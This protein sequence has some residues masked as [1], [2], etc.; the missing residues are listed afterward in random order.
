MLQPLRFF[1]RRKS[2]R[3]AG[4]AA[5]FSWLAL[6]MS[7]GVAAVSPGPTPVS[8]AANTYTIE[9][10]PGA[11]LHTALLRS[12]ILDPEHGAVEAWYRQR[13]DPVPYKHNPHRIF[14]GP[15]GLTGVDEVNL[16]SQDRLDS[17]DP[18]L[19]FTV[20]FG[21]E[22]PPE[23]QAHVVAVHSLADG[24]EGYPIS[25]LNGRWIHIAGVWDRQGIGGTSDT[26]RLYVDGKAVAA[27]LASDWGTTPC[28]GRRPAGQWR[29]FTDVVGCNDVC[30]NTFAVD[31]LK[32]WHYAKT[33]YDDRFSE[34]SSS[35]PGLLLW[36]K[37][38][39]A[40]EVAHSAYGPNLDLFN[41]KDATTPHFGQRCTTDV[42]GKL[43]YSPGVFG[44]AAG[45]V[46]LGSCRVPKL[47]GKALLGARQEI[48]RANCR[49]ARVRRS[50]STTVKRG[51]VISQKPKP[52]KVLP[53]GGKVELVVSL[54]RKQ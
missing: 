44:A 25:A 14:G 40:D 37:L 53:N 42:A 50:Y 12:S 13:S 11:R 7:L 32:L 48:A 10:F 46:N 5:L 22:P 38:G 51:R 30:A 27:S 16:F 34:G 21:G 52:G 1:G 18:R 19:H 35:A 49:L 2:S 17:G 45:I 33:D 15:Y 28:A 23:T 8:P 9:Y 54:G 47:R 36:N 4:A 3:V 6:A 20:F 31:N 41:C 29:C 39:S 24:V 26:V 43:D